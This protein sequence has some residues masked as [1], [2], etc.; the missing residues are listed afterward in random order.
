MPGVAYALPIWTLLVWTTRI[1]N[2]VD[3]DWSAVDLVVPVGLTALAV[4]ALVRRRPGLQLLAAATVAVW[5]VR[6]PFV[7]VHHHPAG[8]KVVHTV[9]A[10]ASIGL[11]VATWRSVTRRPRV[12]S[13]A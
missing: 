8:F 11:A 3:G 2:I 4:I 7:L 13:R 10:V 12:A 5:A 6:L 9:L 1:R